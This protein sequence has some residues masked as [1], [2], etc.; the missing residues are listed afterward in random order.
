VAIRTNLENPKRA[1][2]GF[3]FHLEI[4]FYCSKYCI[5]YYRETVAAT[6][7]IGVLHVLT[8]GIMGPANLVVSYV[9]KLDDTLPHL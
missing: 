7:T 6:V 5:N 4:G 9:D 3:E 2:F 1:K 8:H